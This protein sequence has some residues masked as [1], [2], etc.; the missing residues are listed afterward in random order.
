LAEL[1]GRLNEVWV[2][3]GAAAM[4]NVTGAKVQAADNSSMNR[5]AELLD[6]TQFGDSYRDRILGLKDTGFTVSGNYDP[7]DATGQGVLNNPGAEVF[8]GIYHSGTA[9]AGTQVNALVESFEI[10]ADVAGKQTFSCTLQGIAA[11]VA[12]PAR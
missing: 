11:P 6:I 3:A 7:A 8:I 10:S 12:L 4:T 1:A 9:V 5:L 2:I